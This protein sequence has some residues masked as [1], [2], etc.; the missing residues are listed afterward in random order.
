MTEG[1]WRRCPYLLFAIPDDIDGGTVVAELALFQ[2]GVLDEWPDR[3]LDLV[4]GI[5]P[6]VQIQS[7][8]DGQDGPGDIGAG[9]IGN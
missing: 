1:H 2:S 3:R 4:R 6:I 9:T 7:T 5:D 8:I